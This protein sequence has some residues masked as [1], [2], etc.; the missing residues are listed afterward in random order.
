M[1]NPV[2]SA[3]AID[4]RSPY[5]GTLV[6][7]LYVVAGLTLGVWSVWS[8]L[9]G[10]G[11]LVSWTAEDDPRQAFAAGQLLFFLH[12]LLL[13]SSQLV[14]LLPPLRR[15]LPSAAAAAT[16]IVGGILAVLALLSSGF[17]VLVMGGLGS[18]ENGG[19][20]YLRG[21]STVVAWSMPALILT[22][23]AVAVWK[24]TSSPPRPMVGAA[25]V[26]A[27]LVV[28][29]LTMTFIGFSVRF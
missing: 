21:I 19:Y 2:T 9:I 18:V 20:P 7:V 24:V 10:P 28:V 14:F 12:A 13:L 17:L 8:F 25:V 4:R 26:I 3:L 11:Y 27:T 1:V 5:S 15:R 23:G 16:A 22:S 6:L 29:N